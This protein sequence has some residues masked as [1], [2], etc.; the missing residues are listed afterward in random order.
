MEFALNHLREI[1]DS[2]LGNM[3]VGVLAEFFS[4][5][6]HICMEYIVRSTPLGELA[7]GILA[8]GKSFSVRYVGVF[9]LRNGKTCRAS[10]YSDSA[11]MLRQ[12]GALPLLPQKQHLS[13]TIRRSLSYGHHDH[14]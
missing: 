6:N 14:I 4:S 3:P 5:G 8:T 12:L 13:G 7:G 1:D 10:T 11:T 9:Q 2:F